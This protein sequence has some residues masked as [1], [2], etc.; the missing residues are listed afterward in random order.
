MKKI[1]TVL[2]DEKEKLNK[3]IK[4][5]EKRLI[6]AP[7]GHL[8]VRTWRGVVEYYY[9]DGY[10]AGNEVNK[11]GRY[12][13]KKEQA[14]AKKLAQR[15]YD[16]HLLKISKERVEAIEWFVEKY[17]NNNLDEVYRT[18]NPSRKVLIDE[19]Y[20]CDE[21]YVKRW[22]AIE[23]QG[24]YIDD[25]V[26]EIVTNKGERVRSKSEKIIADKLSAL[27]IPYRYEY[28]II[29]NDSTKV[30]PDFTILKM[31]EREEIYLEH[32]G[33]M[34]KIEYVESAL[35]KLRMYERN[36]VILGVNLF[37]TQETS[38]YPLN[39]KVLTKL[40]KQVCCLQ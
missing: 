28:P 3:L 10:G 14:I 23:Y 40:L 38:Q 8:R 33:M 9:C 22:Q 25:E 34:D 12:I 1:E 31:P 36:G 6:D 5:L 11:N 24:K 2:L 13:K 4:Y 16:M 18:L 37:I 15:D 30:Y 39:A 27:G 17:A 7:K 26:G 29:L 21:E 20:V 32:F 19:V 35:S